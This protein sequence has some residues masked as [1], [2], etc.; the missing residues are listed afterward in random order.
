MFQG[1][2]QSTIDYFL[3][4][5]QSNS[6]ETFRQKEALYMEGIRQPLEELF[7]ELAAFFSGF[8]QDLLLNKRSCISSAYN[9]A[10]FSRGEPVKEYFY[11]RF[12]LNGA[13]RKNIPGFYLDASLTNFRYGLNIYHRNAD[14]MERIRLGLL[15]DK[16]QA[17]KLIRTFY[18]NNDMEISGEKYKTAHYPQESP[19]L[20]EWLERR[21]LSFFHEEQMNPTFFERKLLEDMTASFRNMKEVYLFLKSVLI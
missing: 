19:L 9:D 15:A 14:G 4:I 5:G 2:N 17:Q 21:Q 11:L 12:R 3:A 1:F 16:K 10:R 20:R 18:E 7:Y 6:R 13:D 8:D